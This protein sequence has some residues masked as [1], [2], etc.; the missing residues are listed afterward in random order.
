MHKIKVIDNFVESND[1]KTAI[2]MIDTLEL[3]SFKGVLH[4]FTVI[5]TLEVTNLIKKYSNKALALHKETY[6]LKIPVYTNEGF[7]TLWKEGPGT[8]VHHDNHE[9]AEMVQLTTVIYL[10][11]SYDGGEIYFPE[12]DFEHKPKAGQAL[13][14]PAFSKDYDYIHGVKDIKNGN[15]YTLALWHTAMKEFADPDLL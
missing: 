15:R 11:D 2:N 13:I 8:V 9:G 5:P 1:I 10:N 3:K 4:A 6:N 14:F 12:F 7:L